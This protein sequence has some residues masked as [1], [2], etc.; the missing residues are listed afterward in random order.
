[1]SADCLHF[2]LI[3]YIVTCSFTFLAGCLH[4][5]TSSAIYLDFLLISKNATFLSFSNIVHPKG[6]KIE[7]VKD[8]KSF[9]VLNSQA[10]SSRQLIDRGHISAHAYPLASLPFKPQD[11]L[12]LYFYV[13]LHISHHNDFSSNSL[14]FTLREISLVQ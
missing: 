7:Q 14:N 10:S 12:S 4:F 3:V 13:R 9:N 8:K 2:Q 11:L 5:N 6:G 1:M